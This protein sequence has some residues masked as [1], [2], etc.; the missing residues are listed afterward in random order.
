MT[1]IV[2]DQLLPIR[3]LVQ[4]KHKQNSSRTYVDQDLIHNRE[5]EV[6]IIYSGLINLKY[7][8]LFAYFLFKIIHIDV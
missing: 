2:H 8:D 7:L 6:I 4:Y 1:V 5:Q 3:T